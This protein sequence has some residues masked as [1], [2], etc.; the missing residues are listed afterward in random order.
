[1]TESNR[2]NVFIGLCMELVAFRWFAGKCKNN[3]QKKGQ[4]G[5]K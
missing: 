2:K 3:L 5:E 4:G 1:M